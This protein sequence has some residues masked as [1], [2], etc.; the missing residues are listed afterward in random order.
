MRRSSSCRMIRSSRLAGSVSLRPSCSTSAH[1][2]RACYWCGGGSQGSA[3][4]AATSASCARPPGRRSKAPSAAASASTTG[5]KRGSCASTACALLAAAPTSGAV[6]AL[7]SLSAG[8]LRRRQV[9]ILRDLARAGRTIISTIHQPSFKLYSSFDGLLLLA[10][11]RV[12]YAGDAANAVACAHATPRA[13][14][15]ADALPETASRGRGGTSSPTARLRWARR[16]RVAW[17]RRYFVGPQ[18]RGAHDGQ[19]PPVGQASARRSVLIRR[20]APARQ[21]VDARCWHRRQRWPR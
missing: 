2:G 11:G 4:A 7:H 3:T 16:A 17:R 18:A 9:V 14:G 20:H 12:A 6:F 19:M 10:S 5:C 13:L 21:P 1:A 15:W 8:R